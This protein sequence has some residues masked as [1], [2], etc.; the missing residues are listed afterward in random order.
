MYRRLLLVLV[1][2]VAYTRPQQPPPRKPGDWDCTCGTVNFAKRLHCYRC[3]KPGPKKKRQQWW[4]QDFDPPSVAAKV[5]ED[6]DATRLG[7][8]HFRQ[9]SFN[10]R[11]KPPSPALPE[12]YEAI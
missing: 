1:V 3:G 11:V 10:P 12:V 9:P 8:E 7:D 5:L 4:E 2:V 6:A